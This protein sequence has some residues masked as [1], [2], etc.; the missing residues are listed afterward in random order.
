MTDIEKKVDAIP[1]RSTVAQET[2]PP[3]V[4]VQKKKNN[5]GTLIVLA[6]IV[7]AGIVLL[8]DDIR[9]IWPEEIEEI[10]PEPVEPANVQLSLFEDLVSNESINVMLGIENI[11]EETATDIK[12]YI[13]VRDHNGTILES[14]DLSM[15]AILLRE[16][17]SCTGSYEIP[18]ENAEYFTHTIE[19][20]WDG[21]RNSYS[22]E[23][24]I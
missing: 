1:S 15:T 17:D 3:K 18:I 21:G 2:T 4:E 24:E 19:I 14:G 13:R 9:N 23:T 8:E 6:I 11:G 5:T 10:I 20:S 22:R 12:V 16:N 7:I